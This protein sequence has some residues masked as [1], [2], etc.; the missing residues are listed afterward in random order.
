M[1]KSE[2]I[3][4]PIEKFGKSS[5]SSVAVLRCDIFR[6]SNVP[7]LCFEGPFEFDESVDL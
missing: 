4:D 6:I 5:T 3:I 2:S 1:P 7:Q